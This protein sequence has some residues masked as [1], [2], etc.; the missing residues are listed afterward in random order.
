MNR[1]VVSALVLTGMVALGTPPAIASRGLAVSSLHIHAYV[2]EVVTK[3]IFVYNMGDTTEQV[4]RISCADSDYLL[5]FISITQP[6]VLPVA[7]APGDSLSIP[8]TFAPNPYAGQPIATGRRNYIATLTIDNTAG[9]PL[10]SVITGR[11]TMVDMSVHIDSVYHVS[12]TREVDVDVVCDSFIDT[13]GRTDVR[14]LTF[15]LLHY[16]RAILMLD[17]TYIAWKDN[18]SGTLFSGALEAPNV[19]EN[20]LTDSSHNFGD[21]GY[22]AFTLGAAP[23]NAGRAG[24]LLRLRFQALADTGDV[25]T[26]S[27]DF[28]L[29]AFQQA[30][31]S[32]PAEWI[33]CTNHRGA[34]TVDTPVRGPTMALYPNWSTGPVSLYLRVYTEV[35]VTARV[36]DALG[37]IVATPLDHVYLTRGRYTFDLNMPLLITGTYFVHV[38][39]GGGCG[40]TSLTEKFQVVDQR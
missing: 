20:A 8:V 17:T 32:Q 21:Q 27:L 11:G 24:V 37:R 28:V 15:E 19:Y 34:I 22:Y 33:T 14:G 40:A 13:L 12:P 18:L 35:P 6:D 4:T 16:N 25:D 1:A 10:Q 29:R 39:T 7:I 36:C 3:T 30:S 31:S 5:S 26:S 23:T 2:T 9:L 38:D